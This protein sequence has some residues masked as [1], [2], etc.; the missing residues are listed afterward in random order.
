[1]ILSPWRAWFFVLGGKYYVFSNVLGQSNWSILHENI[2]KIKS[3]DLPDVTYRWTDIVPYNKKH[4]SVAVCDHLFLSTFRGPSPMT[5]MNCDTEPLY[6]SPNLLSRAPVGIILSFISPD[7]DQTLIF[8]IEEEYSIFTICTEI[9]F[10]NVPKTTFFSLYFPMNKL[11]RK[12]IFDD[13][14]E[15]I[16]NYFRLIGNYATLLSSHYE[17]KKEFI[18][19]TR[20]LLSNCE[21]SYQ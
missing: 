11:R 2:I 14:L 16:Y 15:N 13:R 17:K 7:L 12:N 18:I 10:C 9:L 1:L 6:T 19:S 3:A 20:K 21:I 8:I 4:Q 5:M